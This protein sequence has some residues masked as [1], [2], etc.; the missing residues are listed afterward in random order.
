MLNCFIR[1]VAA[2]AAIAAA[3]A[4]LPLSTYAASTSRIPPTEYPVQTRISTL[5]PLSNQQ[6]DCTWSFA[7]HD[8]QPL[9]QSWVFHLQTQDDLHRLSG[10]AQ[11]GDS[12]AHTHRI[13][14]AVFASHYS[15]DPTDGLPWNIAA[16][17]DFRGATLSTG[18]QDLDH[19]PRLLPTGML[20]N[21]SVQQLRSRS[22]DAIAMA[23][24]VG[25]IEVEGL[26]I[27]THG[28]KNQRRIAMRSLTRQIRSATAGM[29]GE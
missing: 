23:C 3:C 26:A 12:R 4:V 20:G 8:G 21:T 1:A 2:L 22:Q 25:S 10:W 28:N 19:T 27:Y 14:F 5:A 17:S 6:M 7:C 18:Y 29:L 24:W 15:P 11:F 13:L 16:F 9:L